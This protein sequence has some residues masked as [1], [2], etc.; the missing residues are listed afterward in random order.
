VCV[1]SSSWPLPAKLA[2]LFIC[3]QVEMDEGVFAKFY[4]Q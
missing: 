1:R 4:I 3:V 2:A